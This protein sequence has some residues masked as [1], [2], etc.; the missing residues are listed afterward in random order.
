MRRI[1]VGANPV[2]LGSSLVVAL[3]KHWGRHFAS[4]LPRIRPSFSSPVPLIWQ[5]RCRSRRSP[6]ASPLL[7]RKCQLQ[8]NRFGKGAPHQLEPDR[9]AVNREAGWHGDRGKSQGGTETTVVARTGG[10]ER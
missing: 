7:V 9:Q 6:M 1:D 8:E 4:N 2:S 3:G 5:R 10:I